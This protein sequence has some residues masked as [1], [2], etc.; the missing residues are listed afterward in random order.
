MTKQLVDPKPEEDATLN[1]LTVYFDGACPLCSMEVDYYK[2][3]KGADQITFVDAS[4]PE[5]PL[6]RDLSRDRALSRF[7]VR[8]PDG[9]LLS[10]A[11]GFAAIW[12]QLPQWRFAARIAYL[13]GAMW[14]LEKGY[15]GF[16]RIRPRLARMVGR[17]R[18]SRQKDAL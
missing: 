18:Q 11:E 9:T 13:P 16:L 17:W 8:R 10:G 7:H 1:Q 4:L 5:A 14:V 12:H 6:G 15:L 3:L 2:S